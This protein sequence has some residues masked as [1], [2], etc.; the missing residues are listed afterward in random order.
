MNPDHEHVEADE[1]EAFS[2]D[3]RN[4]LIFVDESGIHGRSRFYGWGTLWIPVERRGDLAEVLATLKRTHRYQG[5]VKWSRMKAESEAFAVDLIDAVF[6]RNWIM[7]HA[8][9][10]RNAAIRSNRFDD[11]IR[12]ARLHHLSTLLRAKVRYFGGAD[13]R[14]TYHVRVDPLPSSYALEHEKLLKINNAMLREALGD[15]RIKSMAV[16]DSKGRAGVQLADLLLG[17]VLSPWQAAAEPGGAKDR[18]SQHL[19]SRLG[20]DDHRAGTFAKEWKFNLW[21]LAAEDEERH[22]GARPCRHHFPVKAYR[23]AAP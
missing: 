13:P 16:V 18:I 23:R 7:F 22:A 14:K 20:W 4:Y 3:Y 12:E 6:R 10:I 5:E 9:L 1:P 11:G 8:L 17:A 19:F 2:P 21:W 15:Q